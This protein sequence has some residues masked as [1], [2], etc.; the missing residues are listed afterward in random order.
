MEQEKRRLENEMSI[1]AERAQSIIAEN[2]R[3]TQNQDE[4]QERY[5]ALVGRYDAAKARYDEVVDAIAAKAV[6][7]ERLW[8]FIRTMKAQESVLN[9]FDE[10]LWSSMVDFVTVGRGKEIMITFRDGTR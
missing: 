1:A 10:R 9:E 8:V 2:A 3:V 5:D 7:S 6:Q 4:Y